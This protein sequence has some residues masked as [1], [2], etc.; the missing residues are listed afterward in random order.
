MSAPRSTWN[1]P[2]LYGCLRAATKTVAAVAPVANVI[3]SSVHIP[4][5]SMGVAKAVHI[6]AATRRQR[7]RSLVYA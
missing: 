7:R 1:A 3:T 6:V 2:W 4:R 5:R